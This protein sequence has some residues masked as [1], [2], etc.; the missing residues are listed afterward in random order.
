MANCRTAKALIISFGYTSHAAAH[1]Y[2]PQKLWRN[3]KQIEFPDNQGKEGNTYSGELFLEESLDWIETN[4]DTPFFLHISLQQPHADL[5]VPP[6]ERE[7]FIGH[8]EEKPYGGGHY[9]AETH[10]KATF[11]AMVSFL[12]QLR[13]ENP[14]ATEAT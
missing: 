5:Q 2:Y 6:E 14:G 9:R 13:W 4:R 8:F 7:K 3:G 10:P 11:V 1:R 12:G